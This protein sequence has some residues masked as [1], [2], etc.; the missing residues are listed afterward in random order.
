MDPG[1]LFASVRVCV[2]ARCNN[3]RVHYTFVFRCFA[4]PRPVQRECERDRER[5]SE[6]ERQPAQSRARNSIRAHRMM[7]LMVN[8]QRERSSVARALCVSRNY[9]AAKRRALVL[10]VAQ[11]CARKQKRKK[12][13]TSCAECMS[14][15]CACVQKL[16]MSTH[17]RVHAHARPSNGEW[18]ISIVRRM[19]RYIVQWTAL[20]RR[21][22]FLGMRSVGIR[23]AVAIT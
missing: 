13:R 11:L 18:H 7:M 5:A 3:Q 2:C 21:K 9:T 4:S 20:V 15:I 8:T 6:R 1:F 10:A 16:L 12:R 14:S 19:P 22:F 23:T 17:T